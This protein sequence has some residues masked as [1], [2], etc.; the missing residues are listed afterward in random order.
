MSENR[1][2]GRENQLPWS[3]PED[4]QYFRTTTKGKVVIMGR[5][6]YESL[7]RP[8]PQ[9][10]NI[11]LSRS[12][13]GASRN[14]LPEGVLHFSDWKKCLHYCEENFSD[15]EVFVIGGGEI[16]QLAWQNLD[17]VYLT[18]VHSEISGDALFPEIRK[19]PQ[20]RLVS[21]RTS[22]QETPEP[23]AFTF[24]VYERWK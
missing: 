22:S 21:E 23:R 18:V 10:T 13:E 3:I 8:L 24:Q 9:R 16:Y 17:R 6:T 15:Q 12:L 1:V 4:L 5:K 14:K 2:I 19:D 11:I 20:F 7:G